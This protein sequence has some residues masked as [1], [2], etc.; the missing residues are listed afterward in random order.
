MGSSTMASGAK[1]G[2]KPGQSVEQ[3][4]SGGCC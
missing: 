2:I 3:A 1:G 4:S